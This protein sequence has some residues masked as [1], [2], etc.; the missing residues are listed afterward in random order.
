M[1]TSRDYAKFKRLFVGPK[2]PRSIKKQRRIGYAP[3]MPATKP[4]GNWFF[5]SSIITIYGL[6]EQEQKKAIWSSYVVA[7][8]KQRDKSMPQWANKKAIQK[9]Y[10]QARY[11]TKIT[12]I[13]HEVDHI[14]PSNH[15]L[16]CGLHIESNLQILTETENRIKSNH[17]VLA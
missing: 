9:I 13:N 6:T 17:F 7:R 14:I 15:P 8:R 11:L 16:V 1:D 5:K 12:G 10:A 3:P 2:L 4:S